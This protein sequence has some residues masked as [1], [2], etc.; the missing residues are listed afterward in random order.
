MPRRPDNF[1][2]IADRVINTQ[3][4]LIRLMKDE[5]DTV[6]PVS[7]LS[8]TEQTVL[9]AIRANPTFS[10]EKLAGHCNLLR[11][12]IARTIRILQAEG[13]IRRVGFDKSGR[14]VIVMKQGNK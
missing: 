11:Q 12:I 3:Y 2:F 14:W 6:N 9:S 13:Y 7:A 8:K 1:D 5:N 4:D 10:Y